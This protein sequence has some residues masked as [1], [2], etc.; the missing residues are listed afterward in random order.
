MSERSDG[1]VRLFQHHLPIMAEN[2]IVKYISQ[3]MVWGSLVVFNLERRQN[4]DKTI[5]SRNMN[6]V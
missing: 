5:F 2:A 6:C 1:S 3:H 4:G